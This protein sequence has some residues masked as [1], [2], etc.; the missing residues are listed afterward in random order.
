MIKVKAFELN[1]SEIF[2][3]HGLS[4]DVKFLCILGIERVG[5]VE[6]MSQQQQQDSQ[7]TIGQPVADLVGGMGRQYDG[8]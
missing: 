2:T 1:R 6:Q 4:P 3:R 7:I 8:I 5:I